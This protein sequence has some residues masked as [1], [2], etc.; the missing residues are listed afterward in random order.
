MIFHP[1]VVVGVG[2]AGA[3]HV[4]S[5]AVRSWTW[6]KKLFSKTEKPAVPSNIAASIRRVFPNGGLFEFC[7]SW[8]KGGTPPQAP[9]A[10]AIG[11]PDSVLPVSASL[12]P[13]IIGN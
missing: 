6:L 10:P 4:W 13:F 12:L 7:F 11:Q 1:V 8:Q 5:L 2:V 3:P 9:A